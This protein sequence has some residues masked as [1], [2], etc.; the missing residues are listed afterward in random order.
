MKKIVQ[1]TT[2]KEIEIEI[3]DEILGENAVSL[4]SE[5][6]FEIDDKDDIFKHAAHNAN[7]GHAGFVID[8][9]GLLGENG[10]S[11]SEEPNTTFK[12]LNTHTD[13]EVL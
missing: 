9:I 4:F 13:Y 5:H 12:V 10:V 3:P 8:F 6:V 7:E 1:V 2:V 11:Y